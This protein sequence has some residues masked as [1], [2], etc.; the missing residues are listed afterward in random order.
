MKTNQVLETRDRELCGRRVRQRT[1]DSFMSLNDILAVGKLYRLSNGL[2]DINFDK[3]LLT[4]NVKEFL[5]ELENQIQTKPYLK[6]AKNRTGWV[7]PYFAI[8]ILIH[9]NPRFEV[10]VYKWLFDYLIENRINSGDSYLRMCGALFKYSRDKTNF[11]KSM[12]IISNNIKNFFNVTNWNTC[13]NEILKE[14]DR[15]QNDI[16]DFCVMFK[17]AREGLVFACKVFA[18]KKNLS[19]DETIKKICCKN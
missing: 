19:L 1:K 10:S 5:D 11:R 4:Q 18:S 2:P 9:F 16:A 14:R 12:P 7:H 6:G 13:S 17:D 15:L 3:Y 8:K